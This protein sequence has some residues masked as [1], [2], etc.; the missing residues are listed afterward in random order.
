MKKIYISAGHSTKKGRDMGAVGNG[1]IEGVLA[2]ELRKEIMF[3]LKK[4]G[5]TAIA[6]GSDTILADT[7]K[8]F[9]KLTTKNDIVVDIHFNAGSSKATGTEVLVP[10]DATSFETSLASD[11]AREMADE[12]EIPLRGNFKGKVGVK[13]EAES[14]HGRLGFLHLEGENVL[15]EVCFISNEHD[16]RKYNERKLKLAARIANVLYE[17]ATG[18]VVKFYKVVK[19]DTLTK[20]AIKNATT[21]TKLKKDNG[22]QTDA[23]QIGQKLKL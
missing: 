22:L 4:L 18:D 11:I 10:S 5:I 3:F 16:V 13:S 9:R 1:Y 15:L 17:Y 12:L 7:L 6:D 14:H 23:L 20:I 19:G 8:V 2:D 21:V